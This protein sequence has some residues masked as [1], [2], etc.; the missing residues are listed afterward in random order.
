MSWGVNWK[1]SVGLLGVGIKYLAVTML[2]PLVVAVAYG[3]DIWV[4]VI[5]IALV[6]AIGFLVERDGSTSHII[7]EEGGYGP[8]VAA[9][10]RGVKQMTFEPGTDRGQPVSTWRSLPFTFQIK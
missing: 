9:A 4:F 8:F 3:E 1:A 5:S 7:V 6:A 10:V 2:V